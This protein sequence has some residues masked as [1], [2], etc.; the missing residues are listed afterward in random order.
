M[1]LTPQQV[2]SL[3]TFF[4]SV[5][6]ISKIQDHSQQLGDKATLMKLAHLTAT[7]PLEQQR[8]LIDE[9]GENATKTGKNY[10]L[11]RPVAA[12]MADAIK[13]LAARGIAWETKT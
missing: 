6:H 1:Q 3:F 7:C 4:V 10:K 2:H 8:A 11:D 12:F 9:L 13:M 5:L